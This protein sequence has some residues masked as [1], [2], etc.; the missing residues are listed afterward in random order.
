MSYGNEDETANFAEESLQPQSNL[1]SMEAQNAMMLEKALLDLTPE[2]A[3][4]MNKKK[5]TM[6]WDAKKRK[7]VK[8]TDEEAGLSRNKRQKMELGNG[9]MVTT[10]ARPQGEMYEQWKK[11]SKRE[12][13]LAGTADEVDERPRP[14]FRYNTKVPDELRSAND[15][16]KLAKNRDDNK[17]KNMKKDKR[18]KIEGKM[19]KAKNAERNAKLGKNRVSMKMKAIVR[20]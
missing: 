3:V 7:F 12:V 5:R 17:L 9:K 2:D 1:R 18:K 10:S 8:Q 16:R 19:R 20:R 15:I 6:R 11:K 4:E 14:N 13:S